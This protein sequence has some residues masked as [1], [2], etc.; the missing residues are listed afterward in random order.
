[1]ILTGQ[2]MLPKGSN[3]VCLAPG[4]LKIEDGII[5]E[6]AKGEL[7]DDADAGDAGTLIAPGFVDAHVHLP[8]FDAIGAHGMGLLDWLERVIFPAETRWGDTAY[9]SK[10]AETSLRRM[11]AHGTIACAAYST[12]HYAGVHAALDI[13]KKLGMRAAIGQV[14]MDMQSPSELQRPSEQLVEETASLLA[15]WPRY[16]R[17]GGI[18]RVFAT[19]NPRFAI[20]CSTGLMHQASELAHA[21]RA[22]VQTHLAEMPGECALACELHNAESYTQ[23]YSTAGLLGDN[24]L[25]AHGIHLSP[26][27]CTQIAQT[28]ATVVHCPLA[29]EFLSSGVMDRDLWIKR[30]MN[31]ALGSDIGAGYEVSMVRNARAMIAAAFYAGSRPATVEQSWWQI[32]RGNALLLGWD[33]IG[34]LREGYSADLVI[35]RPEGEWFKSD[36]ALGY[37]MH[38]WDDRWLKQLVLSGELTIL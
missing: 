3:G 31:L 37:L 34:M 30:R 6:I 9:A 33:D 5:T 19:I 8:Q 13:A 29:N 25:L 14:L 35:A 18:R 27:E 17:R 23:I 12:V 21:H 26:E 2:L 32:T 10:Q 4:W 36:H 20:T 24:T 11:L 15:T 7:R 1:M 16:E 28:N 38:A 22:I